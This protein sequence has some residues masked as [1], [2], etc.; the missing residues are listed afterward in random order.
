MPSKTRE[1]RLEQKKYIEVKLNE[2]LS[3]LSEAGMDPQT[4]AKDRAVRKLRADLRKSSER[5]TAIDQ[6]EKKIEEMANAK[7]EK[8]EKPKEKREKKAK[9]EDDQT[10]VSKR[11][12][13]KLAK[14][15]EKDKK[16]GEEGGS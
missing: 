9:A 14:Q 5:L 3:V 12:Q 4:I 2:R 16:Q 11:Q 6:K 7:K 15:K 1:A 10:E 8:T 13:K